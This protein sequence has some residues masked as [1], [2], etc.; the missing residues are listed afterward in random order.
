MVQR[1][2]GEAGALHRFQAAILPEKNRA[3]SWFRDTAQEHLYRKRELVLLLE[4]HDLAVR[5][6]KADRVGYIVYQDEFQVM[7][8]PFAE[9][10][11]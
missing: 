10:R 2:S 5:M 9:T 1:K 4:H 3:L 7:A 6:L 11:C 8:E